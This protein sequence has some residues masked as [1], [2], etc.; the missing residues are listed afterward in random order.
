MKRTILTLLLLLIA[1]SSAV[2]EPCDTGCGT[3][4]SKFLAIAERS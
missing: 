1:A 4:K 2:S 3:F